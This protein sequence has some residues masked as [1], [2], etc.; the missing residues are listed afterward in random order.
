MAD[1]VITALNATS[2][3]GQFNYEG[4]TGSFNADGNKT[5]QNINGNKEGIGS[6]DAYK[7]GDTFQYNLHPTSLDKSAGLAALAGGAVEAVQE[8]LTIEE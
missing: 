4:C 6:F 7:M 5:L 1:K 3:N 8:E 2:W